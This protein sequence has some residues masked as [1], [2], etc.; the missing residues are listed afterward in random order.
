VQNERAKAMDSKVSTVYTGRVIYKS[1]L[2]WRTLGYRKTARQQFGQH[3]EKYRRSAIHGDQKTLEHI[4]EILSPDGWEKAADIGCG[5]GHM[6]TA[7]AGKVRD[8]VAVD[9][10]PQMLFQTASM[11]VERGLSNVVTC[12]GDVQNLPF[13]AEAFDIVTCRIV[14]HHVAN[15]DRAAVEMGRVLKAG[16]KLFIQDILGSDDV[17]ARNY[18]DE[19]ERLR[20][21]SH[22]KDYNSEEWNRF[23]ERAG[24][25]VSHWE[26]MRGSYQLSDWT[27]RSGTPRDSL[28]LIV[29]RLEHMPKNVGSHLRARYTDGD[30]TIP[31]RYL[32]AVATKR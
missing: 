8:L 18:M 9:V 15:A 21:P 10:T 30:W 25:E 20:D 5:G 6:A 11:A 1:G 23:F 19:I 2:L 32:L 16:G 22:V 28:D 14:I 7:L 17:A 24:F 3:A 29:D 13:R 26:T 12:L 27:L 4:L 31:M